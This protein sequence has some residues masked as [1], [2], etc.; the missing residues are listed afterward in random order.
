MENNIKLEMDMLYEKLKDL[1]YNY[2]TLDKSDVSD[3]EYDML[4]RRLAEL[5]KSY[6]NY[7]KEKS[8][9][10]NIGN[11][12]LSEFK[13]VTH[14]V[15]M[16]SLQDAFS[17]EEILDFDRRMQSITKS[18]NYVAELK[19]D[20]LS[21]SLE[22]ENGIFVRGTTRGNGLVGEDVT[23][24]LKTIKDLPK[25]IDNAPQSLIVRGEVY[26]KK[27][28]LERLNKEKIANNEPPFANARNAAAGSLRQLNSEI[29]KKRELSVIIFNLQYIKGYEVKKHSESLDYLANLGFTVSPYHNVYNN[30]D[31]LWDEILS[32]SDKRESF[33]F[34]IDGAVI[35]ID[36]LKL[37]EQ[38]GSTSKFPKWAIAYK[39]PPEQKE[40]KLLDIV[41]KV[42]RTGVI[43]PN[44]VLEPV[45]LAGSVVSKATLHNRDFIKARQIKIGDI[46]VVQKAGDIIP[47]IVRV[48]ISKR[49]GQEKEF[50]MPNTCPSCGALLFTDD[51][52]AA[53]RCTNSE[54]EAQ[55]LKNIIHF[56]SKPAMN[57]EG[58]GEGVVVQLINA[59]NIKSPADLYNITAEEICNIDRQGEKSASNL[60]NSIN[61]SKENVLYRLIFALGILN[62]GEKTAKLLAKKFKSIDNLITATESELVSLDDI[63]E[64]T[65]KSIVSYFALPS[66]THYLN[67]LKDAG[68]NF[69]D[70]TKEVSDKLADKTFVITGTL[71]T[72]KREQAKAIIEENGGNV[73]SSVSKST[74]YLLAG[75][76]AGSK[77]SKAESLGVTVITEQQLMEL[78]S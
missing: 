65:A 16:E 15:P 34:D 44:A 32:F 6:P 67:S 37:R 4:S 55:M 20:G 52:E 59:L 18:P 71:P 66:T 7:S 3:Y 30:L 63:G 54:C 57:I 68:V 58:L 9:T 21:V 12:I 19:I 10:K 29:A 50:I 26:M 25:K 53:V 48:N 27:E 22:Y 47:E 74:D 14:K 62:V 8:P 33:A 23:E 2:Y 24:N 36:D 5:E 49:T 46:V 75:E 60:I 28:V 17:F 69:S 77:L 41:L 43:T 64:I 76:K 78:I 73:S 13:S 31:A 61:K 56:A 45:K 72:L 70:D 1:S 39:Y 35:K 40:T 38:I 42:G 11:V 51:S